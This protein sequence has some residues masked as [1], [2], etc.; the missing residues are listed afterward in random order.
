[1][2][3]KLSIEEINTVMAGLGKLPFEAVFKVVDTIQKQVVSQLN[4]NN[5]SA[6]GTEAAKSE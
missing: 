1:M 6:V 4:Q 3:L 5:Q 2:E